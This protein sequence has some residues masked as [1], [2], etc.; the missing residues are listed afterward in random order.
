MKEMLSCTQLLKVVRESFSKIKG[1]AIRDG[2]ISLQDCLM[3]GYA[4]FSLKYP[5]LLQFDH[6]VREDIISHNLQKIYNLSQVPSDTQMRERLDEV[7]PSK[8]RKTYKSLLA[9]VQR[10]KRLEL[11]RYYEGRYLI[12]IDGTGYFYSQDVHCDQCCQKHHKDGS[13]SYYHQMLSA[14]IVHPDQKVVLPFAPE[15]IMKADGS[16]KNDCEHNAAK[17][18]LD[19]LKREHPHL[20]AVITGDGLYP[21][22]P[23]IKR[24]KQDDYRFILVAKEKDLKYLFSEFRALPKES[25]EIQDKKVTH[26]FE[27]ANGHVLNDS[28]QDCLVNVLEYWE[29]HAN[30]KKQHWVWITDIPLSKDNVYKIMRGGR[31]RH[32]IENETFNTLKNQGYQ[33]EHNFGHGNKHLSTVFAH[34]MLIAFFVDQLQQLG[35]K[36]FTKAL[37][38][39]HSRKSLWERK[40]SYF[41]QFYI[42]SLDDLWNALAFGH[43]GIYI[44][45][46]TS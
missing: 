30:G 7:L 25:H 32:K 14:A 38:R 10:S 24:L 27:W 39:L 1:P 37:V 35:C 46:N 28:H 40:R 29:D 13:V 2:S 31:A 44:S 36:L 23:F 3:S 42:N 34:L 6:Q 43:K 4:L 8:L 16:K 17:R 5:S 15:P 18:F 26:R 9:Q 20:K 21:D 19:N 33:F 22:G 11:F 45:P 12:P 41:F